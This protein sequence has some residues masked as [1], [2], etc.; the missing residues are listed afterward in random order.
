MR[1]RMRRRSVSSFVSPGPRVPM[2]PPS[3]DSASLAPTSRGIRYL[4]C[5]SST[6]SLPSRVRA[7]RAKMSRMSCVRSTTLR[8]SAPSRLRS[9]A[10]LSSLSKMTTSAP[11]LVARRGERLDLAA[12]EERRRIRLRPLLQHAQHDGGA[13]GRGE[14]G[15]LVER[16]F[17]IEL[18][19]RAA[20]ETDERG[21]FTA[22]RRGRAPARRGGVKSGRRAHH[23]SDFS[24]RSHA[25]APARTSRGPC[26]SISTIVDG[27]P[28]G[29]GPASSSKSISSRPRRARSAPVTAGASPDRLALVAVTQ[30]PKSARAR[31]RSRAPARESRPSRRRQEQP[32]DNRRRRR[33]DD[34]QRPRPERAASRSAAASN[35]AAPQ[36][37]RRVP[38]SAAPPDRGRALQLVQPRH[39]RVVP[40]IDRQAVERVGRIRDDAAVRAASPRPARSPIGPMQRW[41]E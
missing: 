30:K 5:A 29:H 38:Q 21:A 10:G 12:A 15:Q 24:T 7:R 16:M 2:P 11:Q 6:C 17:G 26:A 25:I 40:R 33:H 14:A 32:R 23:W 9:C 8:S 4:S 37:A 18:T 34:R 39:R 19:G 27:G 22:G 28:P 20:E 35:T 41:R 3:R 36:P 1:W 31:A 13:G